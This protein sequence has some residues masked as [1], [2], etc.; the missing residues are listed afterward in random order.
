MENNLVLIYYPIE[1]IRKWKTVT[2]PFIIS[3]ENTNWYSPAKKQTTLNNYADSFKV[4]EKKKKEK[5][6]MLPGNQLRQS[7]VG[8]RTN[9]WSISKHWHCH[10][11]WGTHHKIHTPGWSADFHDYHVK[12]LFCEEIEP[13][14]REWMRDHS[15]ERENSPFWYYHIYFFNI[16]NNRK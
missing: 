2:S 6:L 10:I 14:K 15:W 7:M 1:A 11:S 12:L 3:S 5:K 9:L 4:N 8:S 13:T 16:L